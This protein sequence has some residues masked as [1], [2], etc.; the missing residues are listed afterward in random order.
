MT[1]DT[2]LTLTAV[3]AFVGGWCCAPV[4]D[5][6]LDRVLSWFTR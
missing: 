5:K 1:P 6:A 4:L 3:C 2:S